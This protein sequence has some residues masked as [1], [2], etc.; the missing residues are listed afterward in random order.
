MARNPSA[1]SSSSSGPTPT[2]THFK[3]DEP[4]INS[5]KYEAYSIQSAIR[6]LATIKSEVEE[7]V[8]A[9]ISSGKTYPKPG[10]SSNSNASTRVIP[11]GSKRGRNKSRNSG[12]TTNTNSSTTGKSGSEFLVQPERVFGP[13]MTNLNI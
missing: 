7:E 3:L 5:S 2:P 13:V 8:L 1:S 12:A 11:A 9:A 4:G 6:R 10:S